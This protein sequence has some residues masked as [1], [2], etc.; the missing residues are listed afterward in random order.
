M[1]SNQQSLI[2]SLKNILTIKFYRSNEPLERLWTMDLIVYVNK[3]F[4]NLVWV[5]TYVQ[6]CKNKF[7]Q[8]LSSEVSTPKIPSKKKMRA[9]KKKNL[10]P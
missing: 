1:N 9:L 5:K 4:Q 7:Q 10:I 6:L 8:E 2:W 3:K